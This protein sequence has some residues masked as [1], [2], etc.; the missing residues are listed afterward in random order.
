VIS[1]ESPPHIASQSF[2]T[3]KGIRTCWAATSYETLQL[4]RALIPSGLKCL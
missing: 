2:Y 1:L 3:R 4:N